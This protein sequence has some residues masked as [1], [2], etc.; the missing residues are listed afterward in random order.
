MHSAVTRP[1][2]GSLRLD[3][4]RRAAGVRASW[5]RRWQPSTPVAGALGAQVGRADA[6]PRRRGAH[7]PLVGAEIAA[8]RAVQRTGGALIAVLQSGLVFVEDVES[9]RGGAP[10]CRRRLRG[11]GRRTPAAPAGRSMRAPLRGRTRAPHA[12]LAAQPRSASSS[13]SANRR[14]RPPRLSMSGCVPRARAGLPDR[15]RRRRRRRPQGPL[16]RRRRRRRR[17]HRRLVRGGGGGGPPV[18]RREGNARRRRQEGEARGEEG[19]EGGDRRRRH[20]PPTPRH[21]PPT[22]RPRRPQPPSRT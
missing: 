7:R 3:E 17:S 22:R 5:R 19:E 16:R 15:P 10:T 13:A 8:R 14:P 2:R 12:A 1:L 9:D 20:H 21:P 18:Q 6:R 11:H 4:V